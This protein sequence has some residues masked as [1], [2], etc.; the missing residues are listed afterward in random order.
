MEHMDMTDRKILQW[1]SKGKGLGGVEWINLAQDMNQRRALVN[2][3]INLRVPWNVGKFLKNGWATSGFS[4]RIRLHGV[5]YKDADSNYD[6]T[7]CNG[8]WDAEVSGRWPN[9]MEYHSIILNGPMKSKGNQE[10][11]WRTNRLL[12][13]ETTRTAYKTTRPTILLLLR[14]YSLPR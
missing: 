12:S 8:S 3:G 6:A 2:M 9:S 11:L 1:V 4:D 7:A 13:S 10:V 14:A 5:E